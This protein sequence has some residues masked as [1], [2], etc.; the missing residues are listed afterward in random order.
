[1]KEWWAR[2]QARRAENQRLA[3]E[4]IKQFGEAV[5]QMRLEQWERRQA[6][7]RARLLRR[8]NGTKSP[9]FAIPLVFVC[10][11]DRC[12]DSI[13]GDVT[14][15]YPAL[16]KKFGRFGASVRVYGELL[17][18]IW[19]CAWE[20]IIRCDTHEILRWVAFAGA[21]V[22]AVSLIGVLMGLDWSGDLGFDPL[23]PSGFLGVF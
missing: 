8:Q 22:S 19:P 7:K 17:S 20:S 5:E 12:R 16:R 15:R 21:V 18:S 10:L 3:E 23:D 4:T 1:M 2:F 13:L 14:E 9:W 11:P 6:R